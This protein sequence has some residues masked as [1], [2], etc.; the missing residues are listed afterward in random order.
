LP[1]VGATAPIDRID[2]RGRPVP[3]G[4]AWPSRAGRSRQATGWAYGL[5][6]HHRFVERI[7]RSILDRLSR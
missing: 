1:L 2:R 5:Q 7:T 3:S 4:T 6:G